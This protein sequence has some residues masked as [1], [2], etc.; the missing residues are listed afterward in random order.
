MM[1]YIKSFFFF[2]CSTTVTD[3]FICLAHLYGAKCF[4]F[5]LFLNFFILKF[6]S[7]FLLDIFFLYISNAIPKAPYAPTLPCS[8][9]HLLPL[10]GPG[11]PLY[12]GI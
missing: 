7:S 5:Y 9:T 12:W 3:T 6:F 1:G 2:L 4:S 8:P 11:I 10:S